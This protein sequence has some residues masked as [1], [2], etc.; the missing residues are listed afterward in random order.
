MLN[1]HDNAYFYA[2]NTI[3]TS[4]P[5]FD[6]KKHSMYLLRGNFFYFH[7]RFGKYFPSASSLPLLL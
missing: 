6:K 2:S 1:V 5:I 3:F 7:L 4:F